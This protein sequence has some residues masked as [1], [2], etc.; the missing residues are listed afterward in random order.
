MGI[1]E[2]GGDRESPPEKSLVQL[3]ILSGGDEAEMGE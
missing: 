1:R 3:G 2:G